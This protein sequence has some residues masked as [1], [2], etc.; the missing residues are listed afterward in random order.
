MSDRKT[1]YHKYR[2][3]DTCVKCGCKRVPIRSGAYGYINKEGRLVFFAPK[4][5]EK[6]AQVIENQ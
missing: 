1:N 4:C 6:L 5:A 3:S 2:S